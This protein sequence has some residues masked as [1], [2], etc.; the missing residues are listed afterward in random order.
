MLSIC[1][2]WLPVAVGRRLTIRDIRTKF[3]KIE[4]CAEIEKSNEIFSNTVMLTGQK[5]FQKISW[6]CTF[7]HK[8]M[9]LIVSKEGQGLC[10]DPSQQFFLRI[11]TTSNKIWKSWNNWKL[12][13]Q[14]FVNSEGEVIKQGLLCVLSTFPLNKTK[15]TANRVN[16]VVSISSI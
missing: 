15:D 12:K 8:K 2:K 4:I 7:K 5:K 3:L 9:L 1:E 10:R 14:K 16:R 6:L 13:I 11:T